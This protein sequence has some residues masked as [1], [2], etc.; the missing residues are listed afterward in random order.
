MPNLEHLYK[1]KE[2]LENRVNEEEE[3]LIKEAV[4]PIINSQ[5][6]PL[7]RRIKSDVTLVIR[8]ERGKPAKLFYTRKPTATFNLQGGK[9]ITLEKSGQGEDE[10]MIQKRSVTRL[11]IKYGDGTIIYEKAAADTFAKFVKRVGANRVMSMGKIMNGVRMIS[12]LHG[13][14]YKKSQKP[15]GN[16]LWLMTCCSTQK[17]KEIIEEIARKFNIDLMVEIV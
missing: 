10:P 6:E 2:E 5:I 12:T 7:L 16:G 11:C 15:L 8:H 4:L 9:E 13:G 17:K 3:N 14:R 1:A